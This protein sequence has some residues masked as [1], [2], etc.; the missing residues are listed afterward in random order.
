MLVASR[1]LQLEFQRES[2]SQ[3]IASKNETLIADATR[4]NVQDK[5]CCHL[6]K[7]NFL[8]QQMK[9]KFSNHQQVTQKI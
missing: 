3:N 6:K 2:K 1:Q 5:N 7:L 4:G 9:A 8:N